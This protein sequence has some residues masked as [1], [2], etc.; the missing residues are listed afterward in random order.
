MSKISKRQPLK[1]GERIWIESMPM[2]YERP[3]KVEEYE[4]VEANTNS[5]YVVRVS[6]LNVEK[7][8]RQRIDQ[9]TRKVINKVSIGYAHLIWSSK[10]AFEN[11]AQR[12]AEEAK[13]REEAIKKV[14]AM[15]L[16]QLREFVG[17]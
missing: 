4:V 12:Q 14:K 16:E 9:R 1:V 8:Y 5:A 17:S 15:N 11:N 6:E 10:E 13:L 7:P 2:F 3:R